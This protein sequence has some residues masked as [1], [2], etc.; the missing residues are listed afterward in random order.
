VVKPLPRTELFLSY[1]D[2]LDEVIRR[3]KFF[4]FFGRHSDPSKSFPSKSFF[5]DFY[6]WADEEGW[7]KLDYSRLD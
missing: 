7:K 6:N 5:S 1:L 2:G 3:F 4:E